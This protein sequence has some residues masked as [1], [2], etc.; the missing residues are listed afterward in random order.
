MKAHP[1]RAAPPLPAPGRPS[2]PLLRV[3]GIGRPDLE[4]DRHHAGP[5]RAPGLRVLPH[6]AASPD[7]RRAE[8]ADRRLREGGDRHPRG[9]GDGAR[10][11]RHDHPPAPAAEARVPGGGCRLVGSAE[12]RRAPGVARARTRSPSAPSPQLAFRQVYVSPERRG[13]SAREGRPRAPGPA[14]GEG[15]GRVPDGLGDAS[16]LPAEL[17]LS[18][19]R[20]VERS[21]GKEFA[22]ELMKIEPGQWTG[23]VGVPLRPA[24][25]ARPRA[26]RGRGSGARGDSAGG[27]ARGAG[28]AAQEG[29][30]RALRTASREVHGH[31]R[32]AEGEAARAGRGWRRGAVRRRLVAPAP[33]GPPARG[34]RPRGVAHEARPGFL[35]LRQTG[36][37]T[38]SF[39]WKKPTGGE[40]EIQIAPV[41]PKDCRLATSDRQQLSPGAFVVRGTLTCPGGLAGKTIEI[42]GPRGHDHRRPRAPAPRRRPPGEPPAPARRPLGDA[43][44][45]DHAPASGPSATCSSAS[46]T[47]CSA[48]TTCSSCSACC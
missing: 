30:R 28:G 44:R 6:L 37:E 14:S 18:P 42:A 7:R 17:P 48:S 21:F 41:I 45:R 3:A 4:P 19:L 9:G 25:R 22:Q 36:P 27:R 11:R 16:M 43:R 32:E 24:P 35:E 8:G 31:G 38:Y 12:R 40:V 10:P 29:P 13:A 33:R 5:R 2:L 20:E 15:K 39:L 26:R 46:S 1:P 23:P 34:V 47:S